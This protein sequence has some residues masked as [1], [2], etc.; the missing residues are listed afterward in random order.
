MLV[1]DPPLRLGDPEV[2]VAIKAAADDGDDDEV[3]A[4][5]KANLV[6]TVFPEDDG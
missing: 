1:D 4:I 6:A 2:I 3:R 5:E